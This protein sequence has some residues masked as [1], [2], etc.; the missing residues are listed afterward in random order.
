MKKI[1]LFLMILLINTKVDA[2]TYY[3]NY[4]DYQSIDHLIEESDLIKIKKE[5]KYLLY[6]EN[7]IEKFYPS[8]EQVNNMIKT[9]EIKTVISEW[10]DSKPIELSDRKIIEKEFFEY[11]D[12]KNI[13]HIN[14]SNISYFN[15][16]FGIY[17]LQVLNKNI[18]IDY[19][20][21]CTNCEQTD[22]KKIK[23]KNP[24][25][26]FNFEK[27]MKVYIDLKESIAVK[28]LKL[29]FVLYSKEDKD[30]NA[31][32]DLLGEENSRVYLN[33]N[34][35]TMIDTNFG[36]RCVY[37]LNLNGFVLKDPVY[38]TFLSTDIKEVSKFSSVNKVIKYQTEDLYIKYYDI[39]KEYLTD[40]FLEEIDGFKLDLD[41]KKTFY[42]F[43]E[44]DK[45]EVLDSLTI[46]NYQ[47]K[48]EDLV[49]F[50]STNKLKITSNI[51]YLKNGEYDINFI[52][53]TK[54]VKTKVIVD[55]KENYIKALKIMNEQLTLLE[56]T[57]NELFITVN[58][59]NVKIK[60]VLEDTDKRIK[61]NN[62]KLIKYQY[63][64][65][66]LKKNKT[67]FTE[68]KDSK[69]EIKKAFILVSILV[70]FITLNILRKKV[71]S[72]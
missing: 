15:N 7:R 35:N 38:E 8:Y 58:N 59:L 12:I 40:Y 27:S 54:I 47:T 9:D 13:R 55:I 5:D 24:D 25:E 67:D 45:I 52:L 66:E 21:N 69:F 10:L 68:E 60:E 6:K 34:L 53:P 64:N 23:S 49:L 4:S 44:R 61:I 26:Y 70:L 3:S 62:D 22:L 2:K 30:V 72:K 65:K 71:D 11:K 36:N 1:V 48:L 37:N 50:D 20:V 43:K 18:P 41:T 46:D 29:A 17:R 28:D 42:Y 39:S 14:L 19:D 33:Y 16:N 63:D 32:I 51:N 56:Q 57:N 31:S